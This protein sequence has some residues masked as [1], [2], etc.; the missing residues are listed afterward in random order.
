MYSDAGTDVEDAAQIVTGDGWFATAFEAFVN[1]ID[2]L[3]EDHH[4]LAALLAPRPLLVVENSGIDYLAPIGSFGG[5]TAAR[6]IYGSLGAADAIG[7]TQA[8]HGSSHCQLPAGQAPDVAAFFARFLL[9][10]GDADTDIFKTDKQFGFDSAR[11]I[12][13][14]APDLA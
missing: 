13:W 7:F 5:A 2:T 14:T 11:W 4:L 9:D 10:D 6:L 1:D 3:P 8:A 12:P